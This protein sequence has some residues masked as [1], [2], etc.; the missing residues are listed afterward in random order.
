MKAVDRLARGRRAD[1]AGRGR[2]RLAGAGANGPR[3]RLSRSRSRAVS[4]DPTNLN[5]YS[6]ASAARTPA[7]PGRVRV[8]LLQQPADRRIHPL[9][10]RELSVQRRLHGAHGQA[11]RWRDLERR[12]AVH[13]RRRRLHLRPAAGEPGHGR[14]PTRPTSASRRSRRSTPQPCTFNLTDANPRFHLN[15]EAFPAVGIWGGITILPK[16]IWEG[17]DPLDLQEQPARR[18]R[19]LHA[20][21]TPRQTAIIYERRDDWWGIDGLRRRR[22]RRRRSSSSTSGPR[23]TS[24]LRS[25]SNE[26]DTPN[27]GI[28][29]PGSFQKSPAATR[30]SAPGRTRRR[31]PGSIRARAR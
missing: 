8:P 25:A 7:A 15:R 9:A 29:S 21:R 27:I 11:A 18:H 31:T 17:E 19:S 22:R 16:H 10:G 20:A 3:D 23:P 13:R 24:R 28:L 1:V 6:P 5:I 12:P 4:N 26:L 2:A 14:G 30:T